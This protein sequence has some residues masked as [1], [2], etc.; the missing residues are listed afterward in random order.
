M[1]DSFFSVPW[2]ETYEPSPTTI[3]IPTNTLIGSDKLIFVPELSLWAI[4]I[5]D[6]SPVSQKYMDKPVPITDE[7]KPTGSILDLLFNYT[8][9]NASYNIFYRSTDKFKITDKNINKRRSVYAGKLDLVAYDST[10]DI[11]ILIT[12]DST[13][14]GQSIEIIPDVELD[15]AFTATQN[16]PLLDCNVTLARNVFQIT[17]G[18]KDLLDLLLDFKNGIE[19]D[20]SNIVYD[21]LPS[22]LS[23][24]IYIYLN[25]ELTNDYSLYD[26]NT[27]L[28]NQDRLL[29]WM[30][31]KW[32]INH[33]YRRIEFE[34][35]LTFED[36]GPL[37]ETGSS[38]QLLELNQ[39]NI[40]SK[41]ISFPSDKIPISENDIFLIHDS[42]EQKLKEDY[43][44]LFDNTDTTSTISVLHW[45][46]LKLENKVQLG[47]RMYLLWSHQP[48]EE[49]V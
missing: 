35:A 26:N 5:T 49:I 46:N 27:P 37:I 4:N 11:D 24:L 29:S 41:N 43:D 44:Y 33:I 38:W 8:F 15:P 40:D 17:Y 7:W 10:A 32:L 34:P 2:I 31:E 6:L 1:A 13:S 30:Y 36:L 18:E 12:T 23:K 21:S 48:E 20:L 19:I 16:H 47:D 22:E 3:E 39:V 9:Q 28:T 25:F 45:N 14:I 42:E